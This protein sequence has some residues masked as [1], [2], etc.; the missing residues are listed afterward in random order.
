M[1]N[2]IGSTPPYR[3][4]EREMHFRV[5]AINP[6]TIGHGHCFHF[7]TEHGDRVGWFTKRR[8]TLQV[9]DEIL[10]RFVIYKHAEYNGNPQNLARRFRIVPNQS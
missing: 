8:Q 1:P 10:A 4:G 2:Y 3:D 7:D 9:G 6:Y 5:V